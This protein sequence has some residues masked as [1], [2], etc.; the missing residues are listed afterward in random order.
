MK[1]EE[2]PDPSILEHTPDRFSKMILEMTSGYRLDPN[3]KQKEKKSRR[4]GKEKKE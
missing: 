3:G 2:L 1:S 4:A